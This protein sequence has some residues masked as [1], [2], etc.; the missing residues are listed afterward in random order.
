[1]SSFRVNS[2]GHLFYTNQFGSVKLRDYSLSKGQKNSSY[3][4]SLATSKVDLCI[5]RPNI[6]SKMSIKRGDQIISEK[7]FVYAVK[8]K[9]RKQ[10]C[11]YCLK[12][13]SLFKHL[14]Y[15]RVPFIDFFLNYRTEVLKCSRCCTV[16]YCDEVCQKKGWKIHEK[17]CLMLKKVFPKD[18]PDAAR[19]ILRLILRLDNGG[20]KERYYYSKTKYRQFRSLES[21]KF[22]V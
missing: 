4:F 10:R 20:D 19:M 12:Q 1:M 2:R 17:E 22:V 5:K 14:L 21:R 9:Y 7:P 13:L 3:T 6:I 18:I 15:K 8:F 16:Y 11:D